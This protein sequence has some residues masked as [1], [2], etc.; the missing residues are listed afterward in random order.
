MVGHPFSLLLWLLWYRSGFGRLQFC[1]KY[2]GNRGL[3]NY[4]SASH[5]YLANVEESPARTGGRTLSQMCTLH[6]PKCLI[7]KVVTVQ[8]YLFQEADLL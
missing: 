7:E 1:S 3:D 8:S 2:I 6:N 4:S 5:A